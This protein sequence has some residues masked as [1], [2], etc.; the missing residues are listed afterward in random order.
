MLLETMILS[1]DWQEISV[2]ECVLGGLHMGAHVESDVDRARG[3]VRKMK[4]DAVIVDRD[5]DGTERFLSSLKSADNCGS[6]PVVLMSNQQHSHDLP[7]AGATFFF[8]KPI[9][10]EDAVRTLSAARNMVVNG[11]LRYH[12]EPFKVPVS[13]S[14][15]DRT[16]VSAH[17]TNL[18]QGGIG[19]S[20]AHAFEPR[21]SV[22]LAFNLPEIGCSVEATG[23]IAWTDNAGNAGIRFVHVPEALQRSLQLWLE[24]RYFGQ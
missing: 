4:I 24:N 11:R 2:L 9:A 20:A 10:V 1:R 6:L 3:R 5:L 19:V 18:S 14:M 13:L 15:D 17:I 22:N 16:K 23:E 21:S 12:R 7:L 8:E